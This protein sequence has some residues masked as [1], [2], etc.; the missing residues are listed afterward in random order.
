MLE[1]EIL[2][3]SAEIIAEL[4][5]EY[6]DQLAKKWSAYLSLELGADAGNSW[7][8]TVIEDNIEYLTIRNINPQKTSEITDDNFARF[9][10]KTNLKRIDIK[11]MPITGK[12]FEKLSNLKLLETIIISDAGPMQ[13]L[14]EHV[15]N[16]S[17][18]QTISIEN[19]KLFQPKWLNLLNNTK[20]QSL[21]CE[22]CSLA[23][24]DFIEFPPL[25]AM[26]R[27]SFRFNDLTCTNFGFIKDMHQLENFCI[28]GNPRFNIEGLKIL[29]EM[30]KNTLMD[31]N[32]QSCPLIDDSCI[33]CF[34]PMKKIQV[35]SFTK[36]KVTENGISK[37]KS[38][39]T[40]RHLFLPEQV[41]VEFAKKLQEKYL[42][43]CY[44]SW[45]GNNEK[46]LNALEWSEDY[47]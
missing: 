41:S 18:L 44:F 21:Y 38:L 14:F 27:L 6:K 35:I 29:T 30:G 8:N 43:K 34:L 19:T 4:E 2:K 3:M 13:E 17:E 47:D 15:C 40:L 31:I 25:F 46:D 36:T 9:S 11:D 42:P 33:G 1:N 26:K 20:L 45:V 24:S 28:W 23:D 10:T 37:L 16:F 5:E 22:N 12:A 7:D 32:L 39:K